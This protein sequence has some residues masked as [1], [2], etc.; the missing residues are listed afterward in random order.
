M[1]KV[2]PEPGRPVFVDPAGTRRRRLRP[3]GYLLAAA[4]L[5]AMLLLWVSQLGGTAGPPA[6]PCATAPAGSA[7]PAG[8]DCRR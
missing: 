2:G 3:V 7:P 8:T 4:I 6:A 1:V 5:L